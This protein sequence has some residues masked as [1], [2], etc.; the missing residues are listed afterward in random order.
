[1]ATIVF[2]LGSGRCGTSSLAALL[3]SQPDSLVTHER[4]HRRMSWTGGARIVD[5]LLSELKCASA[6]PDSESPVLCGDVAHYYL[7]YVERIARRSAAKFICLKRDR[8]QVVES[9]LRKVGRGHRWLEHDGTRWLR[10]PVWDKCFP[11]LGIEDRAT[12]IGAYWDHY[13]ERA[14]RLESRL[15]GRF[16]LVPTDA[17][18]SETGQRRILDFLGIPTAAH[19]LR[20]GLRLN[21]G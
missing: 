20:V 6:E 16:L 5:A 17:L 12:A 18:N 21:A 3:N 19:V 14:E 7:P 4:L 8:R 2:G 1:M 13:Y 9:F 11:K 15:A 10:D